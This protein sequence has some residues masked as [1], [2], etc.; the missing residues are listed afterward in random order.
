VAEAQTKVAAAPGVA[1]ERLDRRG[2]RA[3][4]PARE[5]GEAGRVE[6]DQSRPAR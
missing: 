2:R 3:A 6:R 4:E 1:G 5:L